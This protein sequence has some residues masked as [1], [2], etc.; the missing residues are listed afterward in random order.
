[1]SWGIQMEAEV[2]CHYQ[3]LCPVASPVDAGFTD[4]RHLCEEPVG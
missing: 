1:M 3:V 2:V 4:D